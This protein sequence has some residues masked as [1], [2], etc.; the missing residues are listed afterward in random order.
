MIV[1]VLTHLFYKEY[2]GNFVYS[3]KTLGYFISYEN[4]V[5]A[6]KRYKKLPGFYENP[7]AF[8]TTQVAV[9]G[10]I[11]E[12]GIIYEAMINVHSDDYEFDCGIDLGLWGNRKDAEMS[13]SVFCKE[14]ESFMTMKN[15]V[16]EII[17]NRCFVD[18]MYWSE[19]FDIVYD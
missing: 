15:P 9:A 17:I 1:Y 3:P 8:C 7:D 12:R 2:D 6:I 13:V 18:N 11:E 16:P 14:N 4:V 5:D 19:G 10:N